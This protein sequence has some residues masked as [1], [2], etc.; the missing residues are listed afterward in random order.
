MFVCLLWLSRSANEACY[1]LLSLV[2]SVLFLVLSWCTALDQ[3]KYRTYGCNLPS[4]YCIYHHRETICDRLNVTYASHKTH[5]LIP[6][7]I[8]SCSTECVHVQCTYVKK[9]KAA[10]I[11]ATNYWNEF[12][13]LCSFRIV[14][15][16]KF[17]Y[18]AISHRIGLLKN[19]EMKSNEINFDVGSLN[20]CKKKTN[21]IT[22]APWKNVTFEMNLRQLWNYIRL[23]SVCCTPCNRTRW[24]FKL[25]WSVAHWNAKCELHSFMILI[26]MSFE[27]FHL[28]DLVWSQLN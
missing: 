2:H 3:H 25:V 7:Q 16:N 9:A 12:V 26:T 10:T 4:P 28:N 23:S 5:S 20:S 1:I 18:F 19:D 8:R 22:Y 17:C 13:N 6:L 27:Q 14:Y 24:A 11:Y 21:S 15:N